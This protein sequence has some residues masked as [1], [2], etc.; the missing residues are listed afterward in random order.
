MNFWGGFLKGCTTSIMIFCDFCREVNE[1]SQ[2]YQV[3]MQNAI[4][5]LLEFPVQSFVPVLFTQKCDTL[6]YQV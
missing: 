4:S 1:Q 6:Q 5:I 2:L 3:L